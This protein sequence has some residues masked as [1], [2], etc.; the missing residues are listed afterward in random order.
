MGLLLGQRLLLRHFAEPSPRGG[1]PERAARYR[2]VPF[3]HIMEWEKP[4]AAETIWL[5][6]RSMIFGQCL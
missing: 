2:R 1:D 6:V 5:E 3:F 4:A